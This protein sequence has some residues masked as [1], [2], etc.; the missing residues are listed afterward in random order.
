[1]GQIVGQAGHLDDARRTVRLDRMD[2]VARMMGH[3]SG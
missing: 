2:R 1:M 3:V